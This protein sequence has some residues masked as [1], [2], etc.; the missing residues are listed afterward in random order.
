MC[1]KRTSNFRCRNRLNASNVFSVSSQKS[2]K[3]ISRPRFLK[4]E[5]HSTNALAMPGGGC[6]HNRFKFGDKIVQMAAGSTGRQ[7]AFHG[8][9]EQNERGFVALM[10]HQIGR[11][12]AILAARAYLDSRPVPG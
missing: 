6:R 12:A 9:R 4:S 5:L 8:F 1:S 7:K 2:D 3:T 10:N 11:A